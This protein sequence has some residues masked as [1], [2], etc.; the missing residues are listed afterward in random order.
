[1]TPRPPVATLDPALAARIPY[2]FAQ[3]HGVLAYARDGDAIV[4]LLRPDATVDGI[5]EVKRL[6]AG[7]L[8]TRA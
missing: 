1:M 4:V 8:V 6:L 5:A 2:G 7:P 3:A